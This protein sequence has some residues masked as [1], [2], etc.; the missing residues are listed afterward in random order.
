MKNYMVTMSFRGTNYHGFQRQ[1]GGLKT[2]QGTVEDG[3]YRLLGEHTEINGCSRTDAGVHANEFVFSVM[4]QS[5]ITERGI[6]FGLNGVLPKDIAITSCKAVGDD[7]HARY[8]CKGK[9]YIYLIHNSEIR[10]PFYEDTVFRSWYPIDDAKLN[11]ACKDFIGT[12][13]FKSFCS[14]DT[15]KTETVRTVFD[16]SVERSGDIVKF[17]VSC[18]GFLYNMVRIMVGT[19]LFINDGKLSCDSI[20]DIISALDRTKAGKTVPA[21]GLYLNKVFY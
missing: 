6:V 7:F 8:S 14:T 4:L 13:D 18:D 1:D 5:P 20:P 15:D 19:L 3:I 16:F 12:H 9:Q 2:I 11:K 21:H 10:S 17:S